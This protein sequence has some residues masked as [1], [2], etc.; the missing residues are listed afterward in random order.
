[1]LVQDGQC[2]PGARVQPL[3]HFDAHGAAPEVGL[4]ED[5]S[6]GRERGGDVLLLGVM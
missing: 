6:F 4:H 1:M 5:G 2:L 3:A